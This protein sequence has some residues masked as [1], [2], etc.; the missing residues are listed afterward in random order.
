MGYYLEGNNT[1]KKCDDKCSTCESADKCEIC[2]GNNTEGE[3][4]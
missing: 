1:C 2:K 4:C 3:N